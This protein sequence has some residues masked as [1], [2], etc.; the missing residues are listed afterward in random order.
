MNFGLPGYG[1]ELQDVPELDIAPH[2]GD[3]LFGGEPGV[4]DGELAERDCA[5]QEGLDLHALTLGPGAPE[6]LSERRKP[7]DFAQDDSVQRDR[8][9]RQDEFE[10]TAAQYRQ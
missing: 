9:G 4:R 3:E 1:F 2:Q 7:G 8:I 5:L 6:H 10:K